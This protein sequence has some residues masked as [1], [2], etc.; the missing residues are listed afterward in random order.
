MAI[1]R[2]K[3]SDV[4]KRKGRTKEGVKNM[5]EEEI[6][7]RARSDSD[8]SLLTAEQI[9]ELKLV[10]EGCESNEKNS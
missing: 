10:D 4:M 2:V 5:T 1:K 8:N 3:L 6:I 7:R 9:E